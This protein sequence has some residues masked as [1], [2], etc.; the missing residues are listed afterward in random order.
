MR[1]TDF[2]KHLEKYLSSYLPDSKNLSKNTI[3]S[4]CDTFRLFLRFCRDEKNIPVEKM[5]FKHLD[6]NLI[7]EFIEWLKNE[8]KSGVST[9]N[10]RLAAIHAFIYYVQAE[11]PEH[12]LTFQK[13]LN[14]PRKKQS[15]PTVKYFTIDEL[16]SV[17][18]QPDVNTVNGR[19]DMVLLSVLY[20]SGARVQELAD[21]RLR[22]IRL[23]YPAHLHLTGKGRKSREVPLMQKTVNILR[24]YILENR[25]NF[26]EK[27]DYPLFFNKQK[28]KITRGGIAY[29]LNKY[30]Q[31]AKT[32][33]P[34]IPVNATPHAMR[35]TKAMHLLK[36]GVNLIYIRDIL[37]HADISSTEIYAR[38][39][40]DMKRIALEK[41]EDTHTPDVTSWSDDKDLMAWLKAFGKTNL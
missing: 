5:S 30:I 17:L 6:E 4:Y 33:C 8:R 34:C 19:R 16:K 15:R 24:N 14:I 2:S 20:D 10:Q 13:I 22:D 32:D 9:C 18:A 23:E 1:I 25:L 21:L 39:D 26:A 27:L 11:S 29:I 7:Y 41:L 37:G 40:T 3:S 35:H 28:N 38:V 12:L 31:L 36:A